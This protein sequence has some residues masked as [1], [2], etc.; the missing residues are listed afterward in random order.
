MHLKYLASLFLFSSLLL[1]GC[2]GLGSKVKSPPLHTLDG[3]DLQL[4]GKITVINV[5]AT[6]CGSCIREI[7]QLNALAQKYRENDEIQF[8]ALAD[9]P[10]EKVKQALSRWNFQYQQ[11][12][13]AGAFTRKL[14]SGLVKRYPQNI[15]LN[16]QGEVIFE[17][18]E[19]SSDIYNQLNDILMGLTT[20]TAAH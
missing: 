11:V 4:E 9:E 14:K 13:D 7:P 1:S 18:T 3:K 10:E 15:I 5:W 19:G 20:E 6:W 8:I 17:Q 16:D 12:A 2:T